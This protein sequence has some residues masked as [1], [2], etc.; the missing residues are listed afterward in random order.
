MRENL[1]LRFIDWVAN[2]GD[3]IKL[4]SIVNNGKVFTCEQKADQIFSL[5][6]SLEG[7]QRGG[8]RLR[9]I[10]VLVFSGG[11]H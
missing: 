11:K 10:A 2:I 8:L 6:H 7:F 3:E 4:T 1:A 5:I 9:N